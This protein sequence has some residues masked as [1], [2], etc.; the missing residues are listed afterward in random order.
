[1]ESVESYTRNFAWWAKGCLFGQGR[2]RGLLRTFVQKSIQEYPEG[3]DIVAKKSFSIHSDY[4]E[5]L[6]TLTNEQRGKLLNA[7]INWASDKEI[8]EL[9]V[10]CS[11]LFR[12]MTSQIERIS[13]VNSANGSKGGRPHKTKKS[14]ETEEKR[15]KPTITNTVTLSVSDSNTIICADAPATTTDIEE[16]QIKNKQIKQGKYGNVDLSAEEYSKL[17]SE[18]G[19]STVNHY[20]AIVDEWANNLPKV[21]KIKNYGNVVRKAI[22]E[23]WSGKVTAK[24]SNT[25]LTRTDEDYDKPFIRRDANE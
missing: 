9:D 18:F 22:V 8:S 4:Y 20:L 10:I 23:Q 14:E 24:K 3:G 15:I 7:F 13:Q 1:M 6:S 11:M 21:N 12:L 2:H 5:E 16:V 17:L 19:E 25:N